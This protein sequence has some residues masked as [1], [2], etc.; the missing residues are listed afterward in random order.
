MATMR[1]ARRQYFLD[2]EF[3]EDGGYN[4]NRVRVKAGPFTVSIPNTDARKK[5]VRF[6]DLHHIL[7][8]YGT[9]WNGEAEIAAWEIASGCKTMW[10]AWA[11]NLTAMAMK[12]PW[13][14]KR[15]FRAFVRGRGSKNLYGEDLDALLDQPVESVQDR[16]GTSLETHDPTM[17]DAIVFG[18]WSLTAISLFALPFAALAGGMWFILT[19]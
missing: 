4:A 19:P 6:H 15:I 12:L 18:F 17:T 16:M 11:L 7:T 10:A 2:N 9:D 1:E 8:G 5:A 13:S 3:G 14:P